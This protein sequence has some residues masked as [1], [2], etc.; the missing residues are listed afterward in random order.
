[1]GL[2]MGLL[3]IINMRENSLWVMSVWGPELGK[4]VWIPAPPLYQ[5]LYPERFWPLSVGGSYVD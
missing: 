1:M 4:S 5:A 3:S 2:K